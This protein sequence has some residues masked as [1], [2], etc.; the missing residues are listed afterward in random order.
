MSKRATRTARILPN[1]VVALLLCDCGGGMWANA[2]A[3]RGPDGLTDAMVTCSSVKFCYVLAGNICQGGYSA[4]LGAVTAENH[5]SETRFKTSPSGGG[6]A[7]TSEQNEFTMVITCDG[8][9]M[10]PAVSCFR[11]M[12]GAGSDPNE[13]VECNTNVWSNKTQ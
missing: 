11:S 4:P 1:A 6:V 10:H 7:V 5:G 2:Q 12:N 9:K 8:L 3:I 13:I